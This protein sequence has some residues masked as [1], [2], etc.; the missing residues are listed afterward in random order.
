METEA[1][2]I[3]SREI[4]TMKSSVDARKFLIA[5]RTAAKTVNL[6]IRRLS[7]SRQLKGIVVMYLKGT[8][9]LSALTARNSLA[10][11]E[12]NDGIFLTGTTTDRSKTIKGISDLL[13]GK[14]GNYNLITDGLKGE[15]SLTI[16]FHE[17][18]NAGK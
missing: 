16:P 10:I 6:I 18:K 13:K 5:V 12:Q 3:G 14:I 4:A 9:I 15:K 1:R 2:T 11:A 17:V 7:N 8:E